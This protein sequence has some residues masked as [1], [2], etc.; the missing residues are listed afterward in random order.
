MFGMLA[1]QSGTLISQSGTHGAAA[2]HAP[3]LP[4]LLCYVQD[5]KTCSQ[6][7]KPDLAG[8]DMNFTHLEST[9]YHS[10][11]LRLWRDGKQRPW[12][13][14]LLCSSTGTLHHFASLAYLIAFLE[15]LTRGVDERCPIDL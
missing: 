3:G 8:D 11:L 1:T 6:K 13:S 14:S 5:H 9:D 12:R 7:P 15:A 10:Y 2:G 4:G